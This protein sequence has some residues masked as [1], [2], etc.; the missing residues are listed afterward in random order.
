[1][2]QPLDRRRHLV[3]DGRLVVAQQVF[4]LQVH[5]SVLSVRFGARGAPELAGNLA[6]ILA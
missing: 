4:D 6:P 5:R 2:L 1:V 3:E